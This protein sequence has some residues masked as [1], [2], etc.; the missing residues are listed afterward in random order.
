MTKTQYIVSNMVA[1]KGRS[2]GMNFSLA[3]LLYR[4]NCSNLWRA[5]T[6]IPLGKEMPTLT[7][8]GFRVL[9][10]KLLHHIQITASF[11]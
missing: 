9:N 8:C 2:D 3:G 1:N 11:F 10:L 6:L 5:E 4:N 7:L